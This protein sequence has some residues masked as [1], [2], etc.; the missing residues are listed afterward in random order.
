MIIVIF[1]GGGLYQSAIT[2]KPL[3]S[4]INNIENLVTPRDLDVAYIRQ[5]VH[6]Q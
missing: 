4:D 3:S 1:F 5:Q 6:S 2:V